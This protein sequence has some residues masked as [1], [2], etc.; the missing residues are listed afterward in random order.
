MYKLFLFYLFSHETHFYIF[1]DIQYFTDFIEIN[2]ISAANY[3]YDSEF[4]LAWFAYNIYL[5]NSI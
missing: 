5:F 1:F 3:F 2:I 4:N